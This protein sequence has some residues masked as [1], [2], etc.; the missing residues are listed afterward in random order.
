MSEPGGGV[1]GSEP[2]GVLAVRTRRGVKG[3][4]TRRR[5]YKCLKLEE[6]L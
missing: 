2:G 6:E 3:V 5:S 4:R 1:I